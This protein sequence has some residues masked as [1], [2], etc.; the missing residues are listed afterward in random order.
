MTIDN[1]LRQV[2]RLPLAQLEKIRKYIAARPYK[3]EGRPPTAEEQDE[4]I[5]AIQS[6][7]QQAPPLDEEEAR[8]AGLGDFKWS[9]IN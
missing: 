6:F 9:D 4:V 8:L 3:L 7:I 2:E 5:A 1:L